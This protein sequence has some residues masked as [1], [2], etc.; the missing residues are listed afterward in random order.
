M[1]VQ[2]ALAGWLL[3]LIAGC[4]RGSNLAVDDPLQDA[5]DGLRQS[6]AEA[7]ESVRVL[8]RPPPRTDEEVVEQKT[9]A[10]LSAALGLVVVSAQEV[11]GAAAGQP[12][13]PQAKAILSSAQELEAK[14]KSG[15]S[16]VTIQQGIE[17]LRSELR[18]LKQKD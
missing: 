17:Q 14:G 12:M 13:E 11:V 15:A 18:E 9:V 16:A 4:G 7:L 10:P 5:I 2:I 1:R 3:V 6:L 8:T